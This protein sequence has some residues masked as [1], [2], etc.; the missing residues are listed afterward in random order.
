MLNMK[1]LIKIWIALCIFIGIAFSCFC[2][3][4]KTTPSQI[5]N[6]IIDSAEHDSDG[7]YWHFNYEF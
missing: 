6:T 5:I 3:Y 2:I 4:N 1:K 7:I